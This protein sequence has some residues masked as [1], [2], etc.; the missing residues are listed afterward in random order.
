MRPIRLV[1]ALL[2]VALASL[3][4]A[5]AA[6]ADAEL[7]ATYAALM[8]K[9][10]APNQARLRDAQRAWIAFRDKECAFRSQGSDAGS[11]GPTA[12]AGCVTELTAARTVELKAQLDCPEGDVACVP[13]NRDAAAS[14]DS[15]AASTVACSKTMGAAK[16]ATLVQ[17]CLKVSPATHPPCNAANSCG[18]I[19]DEIARSCAMLGMT[20]PAFCS[21]Y[22]G[23]H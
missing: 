11:I 18:L 10:D 19:I 21:Q 20:A 22:T 6:D 12:I 8:A 4:V 13:R 3:Q 23:A 17:E 16:A 14:V 5:R 15:A 1:A 2:A 7:N 9:L